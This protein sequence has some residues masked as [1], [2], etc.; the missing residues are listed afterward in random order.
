MA[1]KKVLVLG[2]NGEIEQLQAGDTIEV[3]TASNQVFTAVNAEGWDLAIGQAVYI[4][5]ADTVGA[6]LADDVT[7]SG[8]VGLV[9]DASIASATDGSILT[10]GT[11]VST[12]WTAVVGATTLTPGSV[13]FLSDTAAGELTTTVPTAPGSCVARVGTAINTT[14]LEVTISRPIKL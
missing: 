5:A 9:A 12:D 14:T 13:Y 2:A 8:V 1:L 3:T 6:A 11:L 10:D 4:T 7:T